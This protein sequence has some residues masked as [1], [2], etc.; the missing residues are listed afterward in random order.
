[1]THIVVG[2]QGKLNAYY[3]APSFEAFLKT[4][5]AYADLITF[6][7]PCKKD[8]PVVFLK[9]D[10]NGNVTEVGEILIRK[11]TTKYRFAELVC[12]EVEHQTDE[13]AIRLKYPE[14][15]STIREGL[16]I[17]QDAPDT[18]VGLRIYLVLKD[19]E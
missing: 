18:G 6:D 16:M 12:F 15:E 1:M 11:N 14:Q 2:I 7:V 13:F 10:V 5:L 8:V 4:G 9:R 19:A 3:H 17:Q